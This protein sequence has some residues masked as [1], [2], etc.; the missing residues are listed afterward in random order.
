MSKNYNGLGGVTD[1]S[2]TMT[3]IDASNIQQE[4]SKLTSNVDS[5]MS[6]MGANK[7]GDEEASER[8]DAIVP[9]ADNSEY[10]IDLR[11]LNAELNNSVHST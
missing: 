5:V 8:S 7:Q 9:A 6:F 11:L 10:R 2:A 1:N 3:G 4:N